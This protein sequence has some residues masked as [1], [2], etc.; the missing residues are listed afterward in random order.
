MQRSRHNSLPRRSAQ[1]KTPF[2]EGFSSD[3]SS[4]SSSGHSCELDLAQVGEAPGQQKRW[5]QTC[6][7]M[8]KLKMPEPSLK[9]VKDRC[10]PDAMTKTAKRLLSF[11]TE[12]KDRSQASSKLTFDS[13]IGLDSYNH[14]KNDPPFIMS[15]AGEMESRSNARFENGDKAL[16]QGQ[17]TSIGSHLLDRSPF[18]TGEQVNNIFI[19]EQK[20]H[21][22]PK[23]PVT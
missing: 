13:L 22:L 21:A 17:T 3:D 20:T 5:Q 1:V 7:K 19:F 8:K 18:M 2:L 6:N 15:P 11:A 10:F 14:F 23:V 9:L 12:E 4:P 16:A